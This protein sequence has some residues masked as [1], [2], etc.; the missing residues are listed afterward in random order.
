MG[1]SDFTSSMVQAAESVIGPIHIECV[2]ETP[3]SSGKYVSVRL[4]PV[5]VQNREQVIAIYAA[6][7]SD[8]RVKTCL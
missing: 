4:G 8:P 7:R 5:T 3:S 6:M 2:V 1:G